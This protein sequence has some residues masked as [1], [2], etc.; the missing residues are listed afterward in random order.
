MSRASHNTHHVGILTVREL[1]LNSKGHRGRM[2]SGCGGSQDPS[3]GAAF[4]PCH[5]HTSSPQKRDACTRP[6]RK[7]P[8]TTTPKTKPAELRA[9][10]Q[11][12]ASKIR[13]RWTKFWTTSRPQ[14]SKLRREVRG[15]RAVEARPGLQAQRPAGREAPS[16][17]G[18][19]EGASTL[20]SRQ[21]PGYCS[22]PL[23][24]LS[25]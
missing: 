23:P 13:V 1:G 25:H 14:F 7:T 11:P 2:F 5:T 24:T 18:G 6:C 20:I 17:E 8:P 16:L 10:N 3:L 9:P 15:P 12:L 22:P 21:Q 19:R 4:A